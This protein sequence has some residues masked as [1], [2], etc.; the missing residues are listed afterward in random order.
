MIEN[1]CQSLIEIDPENADVYTKNQDEYTKKINSASKEISAVVNQSEQPFL[2]VADRF[3]FEYF[4]EEYGIEHEAAFGGCAVS[5]DISLKTMT[6]LTETIEKRDLKSVYCTELSSRNI[7][8][9][10]NGE[11]GVEIIELH[12][13]HNV[14]LDDFNSGIT[15][16]DILYKNVKAL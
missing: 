9:A 10:L 1:I 2:L 5:T 14:T 11:L 12:S 3:P 16:V 6:R 15:Y 7:A 4:V 8:K 13:A